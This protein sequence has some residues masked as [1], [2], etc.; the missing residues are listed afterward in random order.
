MT[1]T[2][3]ME[4]YNYWAEK[5]KIVFM[6]SIIGFSEVHECEKHAPRYLSVMCQY[7]FV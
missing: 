7:S 1:I 5:Q 2:L 3:N 4:R 6:V